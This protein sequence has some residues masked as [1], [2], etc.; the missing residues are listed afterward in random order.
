MQTIEFLQTARWILSQYTDE[1]KDFFGRGVQAI[2]GSEKKTDAVESLLLITHELARVRP[3]LSAHPHAPQI[4]KA[5]HLNMLLEETWPIQLSASVLRRDADGPPRHQLDL[6]TQGLVSAWTVFAGCIDPVEHLIAPQ[7]VLSEHAFDEVLTI[8]L[9][10]EGEK[11]IA[12]ATLAEAINHL[13]QLYS[14]ITRALAE[15]DTPLT[16]LYA[17]SGSSVRVDLRGNGKAINGLKELLIEAWN[18]IRHRR[19]D[20]LATNNKAVLSSLS[21]LDEINT[22]REKGTIEPED[23]AN[24]TNKIIQS[25]IGL[26]ETGALPREIPSIENVPNLKL[27]EALQPK[28][29]TGPTEVAPHPST[30]T[31][32]RR[33]QKKH[34]STSSTPSQV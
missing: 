8:E 32:R 30:A 19:A 14:S 26:F 17:D 5:F 7:E 13:T 11:P 18:R 16:L 29:L 9:R 4:L 2:A 15:P 20:D 24:L 22:R 31:T 12:L 34:P 27:I 23:A 28:L 33:R 6:V 10:H 21:V 1:A 25:T 3:I